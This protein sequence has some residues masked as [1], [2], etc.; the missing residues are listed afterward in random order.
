MRS[1]PPRRAGRIVEAGAKPPDISATGAASPPGL[2]GSLRRDSVQPSGRR[3]GRPEKAV[4]RSWR[5]SRRARGGRPDTPAVPR[6]HDG[7]EATGD[8]TGK[9]AR[10]YPRCHVLIEIRCA[11][12]RVI[13]MSDTTPPAGITGSAW[14]PAMVHRTNRQRGE[15]LQHRSFHSQAFQ[16]INSGRP[17]YVPFL[18]RKAPRRAAK[19]RAASLPDR[20]PD[21]PLPSSA[22]ISSDVAHAFT[23][24]DRRRVQ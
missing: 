13:N 23:P 14:V 5:C 6:I 2:P 17:V 7:S 21:H 19:C 18:G 9:G 15:F 11:Q 22:R 16:Q 1:G 20:D 8:R 10:K 3:H 4:V 24:A 12:Q